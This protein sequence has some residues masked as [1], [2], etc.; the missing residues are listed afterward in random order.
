MLIDM[1]EEFQGKYRFL[2]NF[3]RSEFE[4]TFTDG[5]TDRFK[6]VEHFYQA[7][8]FRT[9]NRVLYYKIINIHTPGLAKLL[10][11]TK[12][13]NECIE[14]WESIKIP[15]MRMGIQHKF[16]IP[17]LR[18]M[19]LATGDIHLQ[20]GNHWGDTFWGF[21]INKQK[22]KNILGYLLMEERERLINRKND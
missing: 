21:D 17:E 16:A 9:S 1:V 15:M 2:S 3:W 11:Q 20:E 4:Y 12:L 5:T 8:K 10:G 19:L 14:I 6:T 18:E 13:S 7:M 22:G